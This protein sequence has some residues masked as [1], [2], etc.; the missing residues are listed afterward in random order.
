MIHQLGTNQ[1]LYFQNMFF[2]HDISNVLSHHILIVN[3]KQ[4]IRECAKDSI[5]SF[6]VS[7]FLVRKIL[8][9][10]LGF[11]DQSKHV[12]SF[13]HQLQRKPFPTIY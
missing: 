3:V 10:V 12:S 2:I 9:V 1:F 13:Q 5:S 8:R 6:F 11:L 7:R 4:L